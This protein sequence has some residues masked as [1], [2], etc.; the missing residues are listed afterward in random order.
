LDEHDPPYAEVDHAI[1]FERRVLELL[2]PKSLR[3]LYFTGDEQRSR[4]QATTPTS[5]NFPRF[6]QK[7]R[8]AERKKLR[9]KMRSIAPRR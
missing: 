1:W 5:Q 8:E 4:M 9:W 2:L 6:G 3:T 7:F